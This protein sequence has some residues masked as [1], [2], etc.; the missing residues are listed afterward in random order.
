MLPARTA[1]DTPGT[2]AASLY[3]THDACLR[4]SA[5][6]LGCCDRYILSRL[7]SWDGER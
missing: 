7:I 5:T 3:A 2:L 1:C 4:A 6:M